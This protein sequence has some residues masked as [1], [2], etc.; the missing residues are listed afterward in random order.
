MR[1]VPRWRRRP[2]RTGAGRRPSRGPVTRAR[3]LNKRGGSWPRRLRVPA[4]MLRPPGSVPG[5]RPLRPPGSLRRHGQNATR[6]V[7][8]LQRWFRLPTLS[9]R[10]RQAEADASDRVRQARDDAAREREALDG[11]YRARLQ[12]MEQLAAAERDRAVHAGQLADSEREHC[13]RLL[14]ALTAAGGHEDPPALAGPASPQGRR[15]R[16]GAGAGAGAGAAGAL[17]GEVRPGQ[18]ARAGRGGACPLPPL[19][20]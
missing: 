3:R 8:R 13:H 19:T 20:G 9:W 17:P 15:P 16:A 11:Q 10:A 4:L 2:P 5:S 1:C 7:R 18:L 6:P 14:A 12:A